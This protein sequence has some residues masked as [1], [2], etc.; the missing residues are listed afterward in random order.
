MLCFSGEAGWSPGR[1]MDGRKYRTLSTTGK[2][3]YNFYC[4]RQRILIEPVFQLLSPVVQEWACDQYVEGDKTVLH[5][6][7]TSYAMFD[8]QECH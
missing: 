4:W 6:E 1:C 7:T 8:Y 3:V 2:P 5:R